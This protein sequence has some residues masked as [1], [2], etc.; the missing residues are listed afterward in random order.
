MSRDPHVTG[1]E[2]GGPEM[3]QNEHRRITTGP[4]NAR[5]WAIICLCGARIIGP[6]TKA[7]RAAWEKHAAEVK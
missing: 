7:V 5:D 4:I 2:R 3:D 6:S 1:R